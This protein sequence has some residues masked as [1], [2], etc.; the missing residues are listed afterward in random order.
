[1]L[2]CNAFGWER[3]KN[4]SFKGIDAVHLEGTYQVKSRRVTAE[5]PSP[6]S[7]IVKDSE[8]QPFD[9]FAA[10]VFKEDFSLLRAVIM[11]H[12]V[13]ERLRKFNK[14]NQG[15]FVMVSEDIFQEPGVLDVTARLAEAAVALDAILSHLSP[16]AGVAGT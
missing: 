16:D 8:K 7:G 14:A 6:Q 9:Y 1:L 10:V 3:K 15:W 11:P 4:Q 12:A 13:F 5:N 2:F